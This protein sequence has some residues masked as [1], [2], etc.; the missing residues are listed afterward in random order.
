MSDSN[1]GRIAKVIHWANG[2][3]MVFDENGE[4]MPEHQ[5]IYIQKRC[6]ILNVS[7]PNTVFMTGDWGE[8]QLKEIPRAEW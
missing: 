5:G 4:Q 8:G 1:I 3:V 2:T 7:D 6:D